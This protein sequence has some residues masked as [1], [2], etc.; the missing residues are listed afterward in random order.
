MKRTVLKTG[1]FLCAC[2]IFASARPVHT[3]ALSLLPSEDNKSVVQNAPLP[4]TLIAILDQPTPVT[5]QAK[6]EPPKPVEHVVQPGESLSTIAT[7][8]NVTWKR[9]YDK[10]TSLTT[11]DVINVNEHIVIPAPDEVLTEREVPAPEP[12]AA[13]QPTTTVS[14]T[15]PKTVKRAVGS[16]AG[17]SYVAGYC[18]WYAK[19]RRPDLPNNLGNAITW[20]SNA[21][22]QGI[23]TGSSPRV[24]AIGQ[25]G[26]H[27]VYV[28]S[29]NGDGTVTI[30]EMN[31][32]G[33]GIISSRTVV[34]S[35]FSYIY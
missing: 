30:S 34:S 31:Y 17:N 3:Q 11:P 2:G 16:S 32:E 19:N 29:V 26:N 5:E 35:T 7:T 23:P 1:L 8:Y 18:T 27:V 4:E 12:V 9:L 28:E 15:Q 14:S 25:S 22:A 21:A 33:Y 24:G 10:N 20:V 6:T 13:A